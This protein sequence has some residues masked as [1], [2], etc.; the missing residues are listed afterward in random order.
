MLLSSAGAADRSIDTVAAEPPAIFARDA[1]KVLF[2]ARLTSGGPAPSRVKLLRLQAAGNERAVC[3]MVETHGLYTC[4]IKLKEPSAGLL[5]FTV[6]ADYPD[7]VAP[8]RSK[9]FFYNVIGGSSSKERNAMLKTQQ[10][11]R[12]L[13]DSI[14]KD[15][16]FAEAQRQT[17][18][19]L[20]KQPGVVSVRSEVNHDLA[21]QYNSGIRMILEAPRN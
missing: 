20:L 13:Y 15:K 10:R 7:V 19:W 18:A 11:A 3:S 12:V 8:V 6:E 21:V 16:G 2:S 1:T 17:V 4:T 5:G 9:P 14:Q